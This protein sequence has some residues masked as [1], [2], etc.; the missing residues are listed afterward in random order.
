M[1]K[2]K[3]IILSVVLSTAAVVGITT[4]IVFAED[5]NDAAQPGARQEALFKRVCDIYQEEWGVELDPEKLQDAFAEAK[6]EMMTAA[7][8]GRLDKLVEEGVITSE[9]AQQFKDWLAARPETSL[10]RRPMFRG[11]FGGRFGPR[12]GGFGFP[13]GQC[14]PGETT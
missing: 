14:L 3:K 1:S 4:G 5:E 2:R 11:G 7:M 10:P 6:E 8:E 12:P 9:E 13:R